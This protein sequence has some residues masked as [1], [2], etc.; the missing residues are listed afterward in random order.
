VKTEAYIL[1]AVISHLRNLRIKRGFSLRALEKKT[2][3][4]RSIISRLENHQRTGASYETKLL[5]ARGL[6]VKPERLWPI[7]YHKHVRGV[8]RRRGRRVAA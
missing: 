6:G 8:V 7:P 3:V 5:L 4:N 2:G 1:G